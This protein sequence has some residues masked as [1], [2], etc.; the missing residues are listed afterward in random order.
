MES[1]EPRSYRITVAKHFT[2][3]PAQIATSSSIAKVVKLERKLPVIPSIKEELIPIRDELEQMA[4]RLQQPGAIQSEGRFPVY[5]LFT[6]RIKLDEVYGNQSAEEILNEMSRIKENISQ[7]KGW[8][9]I[10]FLPDDP[11]WAGNF[12]VSSADPEDPWQLKLSLADLDFALA[13]RGEMI[14]A[15]LIVGGSEIIP[16][17][18]LPNPVDDDDADVPSDNPYGTRDENYFIPEWPVGRLPGGVGND[19][20]LLLS[21]L[22]RIQK[23]YASKTKR[24]YG[25]N[26]Y[27]KTCQNY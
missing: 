1:A 9:S 8:D 11:Q 2:S 25:L 20:Q 23:A 22:R 24:N 7:R 10:I 21:A 17:H 14:G 12:G 15:L 18:H 16:F 4:N 27:W 5:V 13:K 19:P 6:S 3:D 26:G